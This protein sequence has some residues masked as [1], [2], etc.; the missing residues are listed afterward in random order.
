MKLNIGNAAAGA[1]AGGYVGSMVPGVGTAVGAGVGG[2]FGL[3][4]RKKKRKPKKLST[5]DPQQQQLYDDYVSSLK[6]EGPYSD[7][8]NFDYDKANQNFEQNIARPAYR[9][10]QENIIPGI[11]GQYRGQNIMNS[12]YSAGALGKAGRDVQEALDAQRSSYIYEGEQQ[13][14]QSKQSAID[15]ILSMQTFAYQKPE[16]GSGSPLDQILASVGPKA[17]EWLA[18]YL[19]LEAKKRKSKPSNPQVV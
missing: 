10:F 13:A 15:K 12:S 3:F 8:Y 6:G 7:L 2:L 5:L 18:D 4:S 9:S 1:V 11:T 17:G 19:A 16:A 14:K